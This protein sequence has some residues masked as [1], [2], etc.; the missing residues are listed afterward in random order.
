MGKH[1]C[2]TPLALTT[3]GI[4][5][6]F[7]TARGEVVI[8]YRLDGGDED[9]AHIP[10]GPDDLLRLRDRLSELLAAG[11]PAPGAA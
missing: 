2:S 3:G 5:R 8:A 10:L 9:S 1:G 4:L 6:T 7:P 11:A